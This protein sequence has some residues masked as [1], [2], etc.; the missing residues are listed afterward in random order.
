MHYSILWN[1]SQFHKFIYMVCNS[2]L[3]SFMLEDVWT[4][5]NFLNNSN[6]CFYIYVALFLKILPWKIT[7][8]NSAV[9]SHNLLV[10]FHWSQVLEIDS[11]NCCKFHIAQYWS[12]I[13]PVLHE[14]NSKTVNKGRNYFKWTLH[15]LKGIHILSCNYF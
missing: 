2:V 10:R 11:R 6:F 9:W 13:I 4:Y 3:L 14:T 7:G 15:I 5:R 12:T 8:C 1:G